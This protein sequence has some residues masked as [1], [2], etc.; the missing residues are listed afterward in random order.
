M[1]SRFRFILPVLAVSLFGL[2]CFRVGPRIVRAPEPAP[3][4]QKREEPKA[5]AYVHLNGGSAMLKRDGETVEAT[6]NAELSAG[7]GVT[8]TRGSIYL[9]YPDAGQSELEEGAEVVL[10]S[11]E[12]EDGLFAEIRLVAGSMWTRFERLLGTNEHFSVAANGVVAT[13]RGT[14]FGVSVEGD[15]VDVQVADHEVEVEQDVTEESVL[16]ADK[17]LGKTV[18]LAAGEGVRLRAEQFLKLETAGL[19]TIVRTLS[20]RERTAKGFLFAK[21]RIAVDRLRKPDAPVRPFRA[22]AQLSEPLQRRLRI[23]RRAELLRIQ[24]LS[25]TRSILPSEQAPTTSTPSIQGPTQ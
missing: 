22:K 23:L 14:A 13:V 5:I 6:D 11:D 4:E 7:D 24:F 1:P 25:P 18:R 10:A 20:D 19:R 2:G 16:S 3:V 21:R 12:T 8:V 15:S 9:V 17:P